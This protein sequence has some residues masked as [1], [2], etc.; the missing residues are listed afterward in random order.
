MSAK[1]AGIAMKEGSTAIRA[2]PSLRRSNAA[3][4][5]PPACHRHAWL[6]VSKALARHERH[7]Q[8]D[9]APPVRRTSGAPSQRGGVGA[10]RPLEGKRS[11]QASADR[12]EGTMKAR[13]G[14]DAMAARCQARQ[15]GPAPPGDAS[16]MHQAT[17][18]LGE[19]TLEPKGT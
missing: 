1:V 4:R 10:R 13:E 7:A 16:A 5:A 3:R 2:T 14:R 15:R 18:R 11:A 6:E 17:F 19:S 9:Q 12:R 8:A